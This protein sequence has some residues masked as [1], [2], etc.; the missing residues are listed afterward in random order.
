M[1]SARMKVAIL[2]AT[3]NRKSLTLNTF[4]LA[5]EFFPPTWYLDFFLTDDGSTDGTEEAVRELYPTVKI[6]KGTG[7]WYWSKSMAAAEASIV[8]NYDALLWLN[9]DICLYKS[10]FENFFNTQ[11]RY[12]DAVLIGQFCDS[13]K[14]GITYGGFFRTG[15]N[16]LKLVRVHAHNT[17]SKIDAFNGNFV[18][19]PWKVKQKLGCIDGGFQH[20]FGD[21]D[22]AYRATAFGISIY[23]VPSFIGSCNLNEST[24]E[25]SR[26]KEIRRL[27]SPKGL[28]LAD[29]WRFHQRH[30]GILAPWFAILPYLK[31][32]IKK[33]NS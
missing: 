18:W 33:R 25:R 15:R 32:F 14:K 4:K 19:I 13:E 24:E 10:E 31:V 21:I 1:Q 12:P 22:Y 11:Q 5:K 26:M 6:I 30:S 16:A 20:A 27:M 3:H 29:Q 2:L 17:S 23:I 7:D 9:N 8:G 28:P